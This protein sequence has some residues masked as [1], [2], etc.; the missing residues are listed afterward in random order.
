[1]KKFGLFWLLCLL[2]TSP[3]YS[4]EVSEHLQSQIQSLQ[5]LE[6]SYL[7]LQTDYEEQ[8]KE[9]ESLKIDLTDMQSLC[10]M[11]QTDLES[12]TQSLQKITVDYAAL[13]NNYKS[14][15]KKSKLWKIGC[16][17]L[18]VVT[19]VTIPLLIYYAGRR[20]E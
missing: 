6:Q 2:F 4:G 7:K 16:V 3:L 18:T 15:Q 17:S 10:Q 5:Q 14:L 13:S 1:M 8:K 12:S 19:V 9:I 11:Q 20:G